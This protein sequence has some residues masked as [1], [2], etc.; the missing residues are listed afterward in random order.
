MGEV[1][2]FKMSKKTT[3]SPLTSTAFALEND[4]NVPQMKT[5]EVEKSP[6][7]DG[8][9][10]LHRCHICSEPVYGSGGTCHV[11]PTFSYR[12][13][14]KHMIRGAVLGAVWACVLAVFPETPLFC[15]CLEPTWQLEALWQ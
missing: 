9:Q 6:G 4:Y 8:V 2:F 1:F 15:R 3:I 10:S 5:Q 13:D 11:K 14:L 7:N 12:A